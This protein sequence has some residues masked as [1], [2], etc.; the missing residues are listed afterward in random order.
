MSPE[1]LA[2]L[3]KGQQPLDAYE[4]PSVK[5]RV[6]AALSRILVSC[7]QQFGSI[8]VSRHAVSLDRRL[9]AIRPETIGQGRKLKSASWSAAAGR[10]AASPSAGLDSHSKSACVY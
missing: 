8:T 10:L 4:V 1:L 2:M 6:S 3:R 7:H 5:G 9:C